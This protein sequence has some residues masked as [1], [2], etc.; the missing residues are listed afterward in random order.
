MIVEGKAKMVPVQIG[1][2]DKGY[3]SVLEGLS[4]GQEVIVSAE[5]NISDGVAV[6]VEK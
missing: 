5:G 3:V 2:I 1:Q 6:K 4:K